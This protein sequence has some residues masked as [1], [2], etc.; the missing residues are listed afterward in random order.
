MTDITSPVVRPL[1]QSDSGLLDALFQFY[2]Y[3]FSE[4]EAAGSDKLALDAAGKFKITLPD[5]ATWMSA[6]KW[7]YLFFET[8][9]PAGFALVNTLS[10]TGRT[11]DFNMAE[12]FVA[13]K[14][15]RQGF[16]TS[17]VHNVISRHRGLWEIGVIEPNTVAQAFWPRAIA[18]A[19]D[20]SGLQKIGP[21]AAKWPGPIWTFSN[22]PAQ[23]VQLP[24]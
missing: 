16:G 7:G 18:K 8:G 1:Q 2:V 23:E 11:I 13:R 20:V 24:R 21:Q 12:F 3:D 9:H 5:A 19:P 6:G 14:Y 10:P 17:A 15:R 4:F 22:I